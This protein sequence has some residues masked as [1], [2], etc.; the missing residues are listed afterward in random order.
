MRNEDAHPPFR[1]VY[2]LR[3]F[4]DSQLL[5]EEQIITM[6]K[7]AIYFVYQLYLFFNQ[8]GLLTF[9]DVRRTVICWLLQYV[10]GGAALEDPLEG[11]IDAEYSEH[12]CLSCTI[13]QSQCI[14]GPLSRR[15]QEA[16][17]SLLQHLTLGAASLPADS[18]CLLKS[19]ENLTLSPVPWLGWL[20]C[21]FMYCMGRR[22]LFFHFVLSF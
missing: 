18:N 20:K 19:L 17:L 13:K 4:L 3:I 21:P 2:N 12:F 7:K 22:I 15:T 16:L 5:L 1:L 14:L 11:A 9:T 8:E 6:T 10:L